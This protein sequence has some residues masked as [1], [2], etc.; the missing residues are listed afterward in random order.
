MGDSDRWPKKQFR[1][2]QQIDKD[3]DKFLKERTGLSEAEIIRGLILEA[4]RTEKR[5]I[6]TDKDKKQSG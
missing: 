5:N 1:L 2:P 6:N 4:I 3:F